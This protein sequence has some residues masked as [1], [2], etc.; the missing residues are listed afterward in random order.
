MGILDTYTNSNFGKSDS[1]G[2]GGSFGYSSIS[3][4]RRAYD[5]GKLT[6]NA[7]YRILMDQ[8]NL[9]DLDIQ[10]VLI[11]EQP[12][13]DD[14][15]PLDPDDEEVIPDTSPDTVDIDNSLPMTDNQRFLFLGVVVAA[16]LFGFIKK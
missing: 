1:I 10:D 16:A 13:F 15:L 12:Q 3:E 4:V 6:Y 7:A 8:F 14:D 5:E 11:I 2:G 9:S